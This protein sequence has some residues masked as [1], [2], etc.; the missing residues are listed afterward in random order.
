MKRSMLLLLVSGALLIGFGMPVLSEDSGKIDFKKVMEDYMKLHQPGEEHKQ[1][2][3][4]VG[5]YDV[6]GK[7]WME[8]GKDPMPMRGT[9][10]IR[11]IGA[12]FLHEKIML[13]MPGNKKMDV[14]G[15]I[16]YDNESKQYQATFV[17]G[18]C[19]T[20]RTMNGT[21]DAKTKTVTYQCAFKC[22]V[23]GKNYSEKMIAKHEGNGTMTLTASGTYEGM[24]E[25]K[26][27]EATYTKLE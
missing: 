16:G 21:Y 10:T 2:M 18:G 14:E 17:S 24:P 11:A 8:P 12:T 20:T 13:I 6:Q 23:T 3:F 15:F 27:W 26:M 5:D 22:P 9:S 25:F 1:L 19:T 4:A 7:M